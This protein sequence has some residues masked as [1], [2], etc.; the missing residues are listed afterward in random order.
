MA[1]TPAPPPR[2]RKSNGAKKSYEEE[3]KDDRFQGTGDS[4]L[5]T[6]PPPK[7]GQESVAP[8][9]NRKSHVA[10]TDVDTDSSDSP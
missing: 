4:E 6:T 1:H 3:L 8:G 7:E 9:R 2:S 10:E 5:D